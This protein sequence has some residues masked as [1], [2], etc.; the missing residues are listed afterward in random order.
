MATRGDIDR[1]ASD[2]AGTRLSEGDH[3]RSDLTPGP[4]ATCPWA[5]GAGALGVVGVVTMVLDAHAGS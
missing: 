1:K 3:G 4:V 5:V 2:F